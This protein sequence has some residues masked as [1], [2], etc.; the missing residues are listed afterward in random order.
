[1]FLDIQPSKD[2]LGKWLYYQ[3]NYYNCYNQNISKT[4][5]MYI[6]EFLNLFKALFPN[7]IYM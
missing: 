2:L 3:I 4:Q 1:M 6:S 5:L 7:L